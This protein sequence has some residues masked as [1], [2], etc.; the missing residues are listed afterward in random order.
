MFKNKQPKINVDDID[1]VIGPGTSFEGNIK[2]VGIIRIDGAFNG[3]M[4]TQGDIIIGERG[5][6]K[7]SLKA[8]NMIVAGKSEASLDCEAKLEIKSSGQVVGDVVVESI[9]IED[10]AVFTGHCKMKN[11]E[12][13]KQGADGNEK[14]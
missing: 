1:T 10:G 8:R 12:V 6:V 13:K 7:G 9:V 4:M 14:K 3:E 2:A 11:E 5:N